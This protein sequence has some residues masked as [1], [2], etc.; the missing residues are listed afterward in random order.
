MVFI[1]NPQR[2]HITYF[3]PFITENLSKIGV[4]CSQNC[5]QHILPP[6]IRHCI[7]LDSVLF[8]EDTVCYGKHDYC[9]MKSDIGVLTGTDVLALFVIRAFDKLVLCGCGKGVSR[10]AAGRSLPALPWFI[11]S[12]SH[13]R[14]P[15]PVLSI[16]NPH[17]SHISYSVKSI[18]A[19]SFEAGKWHVQN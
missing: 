2:L 10:F 15:H 13:P 19:T 14:W 12:L 9:L 11:E 18:V 7:S 6:P 4:L 17:L 5:S 3:I 1:G 8:A 16:G